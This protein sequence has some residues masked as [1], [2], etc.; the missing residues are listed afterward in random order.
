MTPQRVLIVNKFYYRRG[1]DCVHVIGLERLLRERGHEVAVMSTAHPSSLPSRWSGYWPEPVELGGGRGAQAKAAARMLGFDGT[2]RRVRK[3][4][5]DF[6]PD[7]VHLHNVHSHLSPAVAREA[8]RAGCRVVWTLHDYKHSCPAY[9]MLCRGRVCSECLT[10][11][12]AVVRK[13]CFRNSLGAS[14]AARAEALRWPRR[15]I[16]RWTD[17]FICPSEFMAR[18][19]EKAGFAPDRLRVIP[20]FWSPSVSSSGTPMAEAVEP[21]YCYAGR[22]AAEKGLDTLLRA[23]VK[24]PYRLKIAGDGPQLARLR[25]RYGSSGHIEWLGILDAE[26]T[27][28]LIG[29]ARLS[30]VPSEW[31]E[32]C[33]L[34][35][36][37]SLC[38]GTPVAG[39]R[40]GGIP[41]LLN[42]EPEM[43]RM[44][45]P[46][47]AEAL[48]AAVTDLWALAP[49]PESRR[50][51]ARRS[52]R[53]FS[54][55]A[56]YRQLLEVYAS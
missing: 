42:A 30:V 44:F 23:A 41:A 55:E 54:P 37:E 49:T 3:L 36:I 31:N 20:N 45:A 8:R 5:R 56:Y 21:Y 38:A 39:S 17:A 43:A 2:A 47:D 46:G 51:M 52:R 6:R 18:T 24:L 27:A 26:A 32:N 40:I 19:M 53:R 25:E 34:S 15:A 16:E 4:L 35:V 9:T 13:R 12:Q 50:E 14:L 7:V 11:G 48:A 10:D 33:P 1:G 22:I 29:G 28:A